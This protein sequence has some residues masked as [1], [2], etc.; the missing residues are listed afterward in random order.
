[1]V[2]LFPPDPERKNLWSRVQH[3]AGCNFPDLGG[4]KSTKE[5]EFFALSQNAQ[6][7]WVP[8]LL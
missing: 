8:G 3:F 5:G 2:N 4:Q 1:M 6:A 7:A